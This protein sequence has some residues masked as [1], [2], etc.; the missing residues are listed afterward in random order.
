MSIKE[1]LESKKLKNHSHSHLERC[2]PEEKHPFSSIWY[3][4]TS[5]LRQYWHRMG[6]VIQKSSSV[7]MSCYETK[8]RVF[9]V[10]TVLKNWLN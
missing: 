4:S 1:Y 7:K 8:L 9:E 2:P 5:E 6:F 10:F 3:T